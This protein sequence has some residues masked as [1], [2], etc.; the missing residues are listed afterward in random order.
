MLELEIVMPA[1]AGLKNQLYVQQE[2]GPAATE[3]LELELGH[4]AD[5]PEIAVGN[6]AETGMVNV[7]VL[8]G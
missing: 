3:K 6:V 8:P 4:I 5:G 2:L 1:A 7:V